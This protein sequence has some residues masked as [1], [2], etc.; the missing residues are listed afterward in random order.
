M[1]NAMMDNLG[2]AE[3]SYSVTLEEDAVKP[4]G[5]GSGKLRVALYCRA[6]AQVYGKHTSLEEQVRNYTEMV[7]GNP[8]WMLAGVYADQARKNT[9]A[10]RPQFGRLIRD[11]ENGIFDCI[12]CESVSTLVRVER[13]EIQTIRHLCEKGICL[14]FEKDDIG[15]ENTHF[16]ILLS[17]LESFAEEKRCFQSDISRQIRRKRVQAGGT[18]YHRLYGYRKAGDSFEVLPEEA[19]AVRLIFRCYEHGANSME[20]AGILTEKGI[21]TPCGHHNHWRADYIRIMIENEKYAGDFRAQKYYKGDNGRE[22]KND[23]TLPSVY[24][25]NH[26]PA[27]ID[28]EQ[29]ERCNVILNLRKTTTPLQY[30]F[31]EYLRCPYCGHVLRKRQSPVKFDFCC[32]GDEGACRKFV[33]KAASVERAILE[34]YKTIKMKAVE[35]KAAMRDYAVAIEAVKMLRIKAEYP[36][37]EKIDFWWLDDLIEQISF[38]QHTC[39]HAELKKEKASLTDDR[40]ISVHWRCGLVTTLPSGVKYD[41]HDPRRRAEQWDAYI[42]SHPDRYPR[43]V[44]EIQR[45]K[46]C[47]I[48]GSQ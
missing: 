23:G 32:E 43:L 37:F 12:L 3:L 40:T 7:S 15:T 36:A 4:S 21:P 22:Y 34:A 18:S 8:D 45:Q 20:V 35:K 41:I 13:T 17:I 48:L 9:R 11:C 29:F 2:D 33:I 19:E 31:G 24:H 16:E 25:R 47:V 6:S 28:R 1:K 27:I 42:L 10:Q 38:G 14:V 46:D 26:H 44:E 30:P 5:N 39:T